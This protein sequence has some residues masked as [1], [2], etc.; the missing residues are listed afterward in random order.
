MRQ[1]LK[2]VLVIIGVALL[3]LLLA[4]FNARV[5]ELNR[6]R[7][8]HQ[9]VSTQLVSLQETQMV[10]QTQVAYATSEAAVL[11]H[12]Y[13]EDRMVR[14]GD[15]LVVPLAPPASTPMPTPFVV[16]ASRQ[17]APWEYWFAL[18]FDESP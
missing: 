6:L 7:R 14:P 13:Q 18:F 5:A 1:R 16:T 2:Y 8:T 11:E 3:L 10:L 12:A 17:R 9:Q 4:N 15:V